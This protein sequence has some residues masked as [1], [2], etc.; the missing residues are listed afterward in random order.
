MYVWWVNKYGEPVCDLHGPEDEEGDLNS[1]ETDSPLNCV[2]CG[3]LCY[4]SLTE[5]GI[6]YVIEHAREALN[7]GPANWNWII[8]EYPIAY[9]GRRYVEIVRDWVGDLLGNYILSPERHYILRL[10]MELTAEGAVVQG[11]IDHDSRQGPQL[12]YR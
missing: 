8:E 6:E 3:A 4:Y 10:F 12:A 2:E 5:T 11:A 1:N 9:H 7:A